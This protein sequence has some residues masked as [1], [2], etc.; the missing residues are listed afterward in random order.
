MRSLIPIAERIGAE[1][2]KRHQTIAI[3]E[4]SAAGLVAA[5]LLSIPG[6]SAYFL[7]SAVF[8][9]RR[10]LAGFL[11]L[12]DA[13][14]AAMRGLTDSTALLLARAVRDR[15]GSSWAIAEIGAAGPTGSRYG[16]PAGTSCVAIAGDVERAEVIRTGTS[17]RAVNME[18]FARA[19]LDLLEK[20]L[21]G[22]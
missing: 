10:S 14:F 9:T 13:D 16:D 22:S 12:G 4:S 3:A 18:S 19:A 7:G 15:L 5:S 21:T 11:G 20:T 8:Y 1:L 6:A 17:D 2:K